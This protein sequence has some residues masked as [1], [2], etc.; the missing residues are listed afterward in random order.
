[1]GAA[2]KV[3]GATQRALSSVVIPATKAGLAVVVV[4]LD[5]RTGEADVASN[6]S[7]GPAAV[8]RV[9]RDA[10]GVVED[11]A[12]TYSRQEVDQ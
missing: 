10:L 3:S 8:A 7:T 9:L 12:S 11:P 5:I 4:A 6:V 2:V 1:V